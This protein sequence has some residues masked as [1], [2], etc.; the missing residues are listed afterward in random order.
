[1]DV[2]ARRANALQ[3]DT[4]VAPPKGHAEILEI[5][6]DEPHRAEVVDAKDEV[7]TSQVDAE[8]GNRKLLLADAHGHVASHAGV[9]TRSS[10]AT[11]TR[12]LLS[13]VAS[14]RRRVTPALMKL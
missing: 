8:V 3:E 4:S 1:M 9:G 14:L 2:V 13:P 6:Q 10:L 11:M 7:E 5:P 12:M